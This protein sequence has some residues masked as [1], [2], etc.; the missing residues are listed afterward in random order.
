MLD[1]FEDS[2]AAYSLTEPTTT[3]LLYQQRAASTE[4]SII[5]PPENYNFSLKFA[6]KTHPIRHQ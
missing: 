1:D 6:A 5:F 2:E 4:N 3:P